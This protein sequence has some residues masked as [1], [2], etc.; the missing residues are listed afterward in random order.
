VTDGDRQRGQDQSELKRPPIV[1]AAIVHDLDDIVAFNKA[2]AVETEGKELDDATIR[3][4]VRSALADPGRAR[5]FIAEVNGEVAGQT[6][7][8]LEWS[9]WRNGFFWWIQSVYV[10]PEHRRRGVF[11]ALHTFVRDEARRTVGVCGLR[12]YV[13]SA[14]SRAIATYDRLGMHRTQYLL[15][16]EEWPTR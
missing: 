3:E 2:M 13:Y 4:G 6:M 11:R 12:L 14:N 7:I 5:Y 8:T 9:D 15:F 1:R 16:E 10:R